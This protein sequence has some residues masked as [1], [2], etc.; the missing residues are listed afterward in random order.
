MG[1]AVARYFAA[2]GHS[3]VVLDNLRRRGAERNLIQLSRAGVEFVHGDVRN[4]ADLDGLS[5]TFDA[6]IEASAE[7]SVLAGVG[8][9]PRYVLDTNLVGAINCLEFARVRCGGFVFISTSRIYSI[10]PMVELPLVPTATRFELGAPDSWCAGLSDRGV[11]EEFPSDSSRSFYGASKLAA[12]LLCQ[13]YAAQSALRVVTNRCG[14][15]AGPGQFGKT[16]QGVFTLWVARHHFGRPLRYT[17]FGGQGLQVRDLLHIQDLCELL[18]LQ[19][20]SWDRVAGG[21]YNVGGGR[22]GSVSLMEFTALCQSATGRYVAIDSVS[23]TSQVDIPWYISDHSKISDV[24]GWVPTRTPAMIV[25]D[26]ADWIRSNESE[27]VNLI[28]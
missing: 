27:L 9:S 12:E 25:C 7:P 21:T 5:G 23:A 20:D 15:I 26:T 14:V 18:E 28:V 13:E 4:N 1:S 6:L 3:V 17:G 22:R 16:D 11:A 19:L 2:A 8:E 24:L 10:R